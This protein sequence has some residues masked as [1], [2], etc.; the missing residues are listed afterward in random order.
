MKKLFVAMAALLTLSL[1]GV[2]GAADM[3][4]PVLKA[5]PPAT[6]YNWTGCYAAAGGGY[7][8]YDINHV[9]SSPGPL[10]DPTQA[11]DN[12]GRG[13][14]GTLGVG[15]DLQ[16]AGPTGGNWVVGV[17]ADYDWMSIKG[18]YTTNCPGGCSGPFSFTGQLK[19]RNA[20]YV[21]GRIGA[22]VTPQL[23]TYVSGGWTETRFKSAVLTDTFDPTGDVVAL[24]AQ[25]FH[26]WFVGGGT[27]YALGWMPGLFWRS[28][29]RFANYRSRSAVVACV[30]GGCNT[31]PGVN[32]VDNAHPHVQTVRSE[33]VWRFNWAGTRY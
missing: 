10:F 7:G 16:F 5:P 29:Y 31:I 9:V 24:P 12:S 26:G 22:L 28:E 8:M 6:V 18:N 1:G 30:S 32:A 13:W 11:S 21:G 3:A 19:E 14:L 25:T 33:L 15:C 17:L 27:E 23:L 4:R 2:A 20:A